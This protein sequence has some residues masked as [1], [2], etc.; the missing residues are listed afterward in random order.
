MC[1]G[2]FILSV[3]GEEVNGEWSIVNVRGETSNVNNLSFQEVRGETSNV[4]SETLNP[5]NEPIT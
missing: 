3:N 2:V 1:D 5:E 4:N